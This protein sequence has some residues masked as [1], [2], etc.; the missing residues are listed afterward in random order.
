[1]KHILVLILV[2]CTIGVVSAQDK[3]QEIKVSKRTESIKYKMDCDTISATFKVENL[4]DKEIK[5]LGWDKECTCTDVKISGKTLPPKKSIELIMKVAVN[6]QKE[7]NTVSVLVLDTK[8]KYYRFR[9]KG[10]VIENNQ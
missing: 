7:I 10:T 9:L 6:N 8:Q 4:T 5:L 2:F 3:D 1:M